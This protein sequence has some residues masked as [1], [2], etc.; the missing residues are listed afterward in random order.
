M[1]SPYSSPLQYLLG[2]SVTFFLLINL[3][4]LSS[5]QH[6]FGGQGLGIL[7]GAGSY[8]GGPFLHQQ[9]SALHFP[10]GPLGLYGG[11]GGG[12]GGGSRLGQGYLGNG[13][14]GIKQTDANLADLYGLPRQLAQAPPPQPLQVPQQQPQLLDPYLGLGAGYPGPAGPL[15]QQQQQQV[16]QY[17]PP[18]MP[19]IPGF[20]PLA[21]Y[22]RGYLG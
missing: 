5:G 16:L 10:S 14:I 22:G 13:G 3:I 6:S 9:A 18:Q 11:G 4:G 19:A 7:P 15:Q 8:H 17:G 21:H 20:G 1:S 12:G 2:T